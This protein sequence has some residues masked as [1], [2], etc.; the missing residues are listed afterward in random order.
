MLWTYS[1]FPE[2]PGNYSGSERLK[3]RLSLTIHLILLILTNEN[4][5][6][7]ISIALAR[8]EVSSNTQQMEIWSQRATIATF[9]TATCNN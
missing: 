4:L 9:F 7:G 2:I 8:I 3:I 1:Q 6:P 5:L